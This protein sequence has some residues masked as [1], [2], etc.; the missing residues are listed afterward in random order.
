MHMMS[1]VDI[2]ET[3]NDSDDVKILDVDSDEE[4]Y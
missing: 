3:I 4:V 2:I 1:E